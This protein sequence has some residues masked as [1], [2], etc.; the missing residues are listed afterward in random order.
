MMKIV[1]TATRTGRR[2]L[3]ALLKS[4]RG[5]SPD[6]ATLR[7]VL[8]VVEDVLR[9]G[10]P[11]LRDYVKRFDLQAAQP[12]GSKRMI[13]LKGAG[14]AAHISARLSEPGSFRVPDDTSDLA[15]AG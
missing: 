2:E 5:A 14:P 15:M 10:E 11:A 7:Q 13:S 4:R 6:F 9:R 1:E 3:E 8:P 12:H